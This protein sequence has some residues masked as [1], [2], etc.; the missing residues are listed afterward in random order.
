MRSSTQRVQF[1]WIFKNLGVVELAIDLNE[2]IVDRGE[3]QPG[4]IEIED[5]LA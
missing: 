5:F 1:R 4:S 2:L 3:K